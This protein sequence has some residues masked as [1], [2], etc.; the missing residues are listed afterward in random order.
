MEHDGRA[1]SRREERAA[2]DRAHEDRDVGV[3]PFRPRREAHD[4][5]AIGVDGL[6]LEGLGQLDVDALL[7]R[8]E[9][10]EQRFVALGREPRRVPRERE[11]KSQGGRFERAQ[12]QR[13]RGLVDG[14]HVLRTARGRHQR[15]RADAL[16]SDDRGDGQAGVRGVEHEADTRALDPDGLVGPRVKKRAWVTDQGLERPKRAPPRGPHAVGLVEAKAHGVDRARVARIAGQLGAALEIVELDGLPDRP[17]SALE[18]LLDDRVDARGALG[19]VDPERQP[20]VLRCLGLRGAGEPFLERAQKARPARRTEHLDELPPERV[21]RIAKRVASGVDGRERVRAARGRRRRARAAHPRRL[22]GLAIDRD[23][24]ADDSGAI[25]RLGRFPVNEAQRRVGELHRDGHER[26]ERPG[27]R[28][29]SKLGPGGLEAHEQGMKCRLGGD[30]GPRL[31]RAPLLH[32]RRAS[33][34]DLEQIVARR[35]ADHVVVH[36]IPRAPRAPVNR[37]GLQKVGDP[38][39][40]GSVAEQEGLGLRVQ[41]RLQHRRRIVQPLE[42]VVVRRPDAETGHVQRRRRDADDG[43]NNL[44]R[45][46]PRVPLRGLDLRAE[47]RRDDRYEGRPPRARELLVHARIRGRVRQ[48]F[49]QGAAAV[50]FDEVLER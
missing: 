36:A 19:E 30:L 15:A 6:A 35:D 18:L 4:D 5:A 2:G 20:R 27:C 46:P 29:S 17:A 40:S 26:S 31:E 7:E 28:G 45:H 23:L 43:R 34:R 42:H 22:T 10:A 50:P 48:R 11:E 32:L 41:A 47:P 25:A 39:P 44:H 3:G 24:H 8:P 12:E 13:R 9:L 38:R 1:F 37:R 14:D 16:L 33:P 49:A 21:R